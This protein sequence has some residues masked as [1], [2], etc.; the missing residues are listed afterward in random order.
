MFRVGLLS[1]SGLRWWVFTAIELRE[2]DCP[3]L[4]RSMLLALLLV[5]C[6]RASGDLG[7]I[8]FHAFSLVVYSALD[9]G[10]GSLD[11]NI[12]EGKGREWESQEN[13]RLMVLFFFFF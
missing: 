6:S 2:Q 12:R 13:K 1:D 11:Y 8:T 7:S 3:T 10:G 5:E 9:G 4:A